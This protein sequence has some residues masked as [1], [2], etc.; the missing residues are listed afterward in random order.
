MIYVSC[1]NAVWPEESDAS[2]E[3]KDRTLQRETGPAIARTS[4]AW[5]RALLALLTLLLSAPSAHAIF[6][7]DA[8]SASTG[9]ISGLWWNPNE[10]GWGINLTQQGPIIF[11]AWYTYDQT[12][13]P[14][15]YVM[16]N[17]AVA[18]DSC[19]GDIYRVVGGKPLST[20]W[21]GNGLVVTKAGAGSLTFTDNNTGVFRYTL[22]GV[23][24]TRN[25][26]RQIFAS[27]AT[28][29]EVDYS[30]LW[31]NANESGWG[32]ALTQQYGVIFVTMFTYDASGN[33]V[34][35]VASN[36]AV[37]ASGCTG[38]LYK[39]SGG[40]VPTTPWV[41]PITAT[42]VGNITI[43]FTDASNGTMNFTINGQSG[44]RAISK[45]IFYTPP[46]LDP[47]T[48]ITNT[49][50]TIDSA[51]P[52]GVKNAISQIISPAGTSAPGGQVGI[53]TT[54]NGGTSIVLAVDAN[55]N[56]LLA[57]MAN[58]AATSVSA[59]STAFAFARIGM[60][61]ISTTSVTE[62][63]VSLAIR[64]TAEYANLVKLI[65][66]SLSAITPPV[67]STAVL[68]SVA[69]VDSQA[70]A[71]LRSQFGAKDKIAY[72]L[73]YT[74]VGDAL[75][76]VYISSTDGNGVKVMNSMPIVWTVSSTD[77]SGLTL[78]GPKPLPAGS[79]LEAMYKI[80]DAVS[81]GGNG[82][83][84]KVKI[85][86][87]L[88][89]RTTNAV[90][91]GVDAVLFGVSLASAGQSGFFRVCATKA[92][93]TVLSTKNLSLLVAEPSAE[94]AKI[95]F[96]G[97]YKDPGLY[98]EIGSGLYDCIKAYGTKKDADIDQTAN[99]VVAAD[100]ADWIDKL[101][102]VGEFLSKFGPLS[103]AISGA[104]LF[105]ETAMMWAYW[106]Y[107]DQTVRVCER[108]GAI[109]STCSIQLV[110]SPASPSV[111][112]GSTVPLT[113]TAVDPSNASVS[114]PVPTEL[115][116]DSSNK[117]VATVTSAGVVT[118]VAAGSS[119]ITVTDP[120]GSTASVVVEVTAAVAAKLVL[121]YLSK[122]AEICQQTVQEVTNAYLGT[123]QVPEVLFCNGGY[124]SVTCSSGCSNQTFTISGAYE[125]VLQDNELP[126]CDGQTN[127][128]VTY[129]LETSTGLIVPDGS[130]VGGTHRV[131]AY[132]IRV[133]WK[134]TPPVVKC[135]HTGFS[136]VTLSVTSSTG[137]S[138]TFAYVAE[139]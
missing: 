37:S 48:A 75:A 109:V 20:A 103:T 106:D 122:T 112:V 30:A 34:W 97:V 27:G 2:C 63:Q 9:P 7:V 90:Q 41:G 107:P 81:V 130:T 92:A 15:W 93:V 139:H 80:P 24:G 71:T 64:G 125:Q 77:L 33:P 118:G 10:S 39:T 105:T 115:T 73:P 85:G 137:L 35:Y 4:W 124:V 36:C 25:I 57:A 14:L 56:V 127:F 58:S 11:A 138:K 101:I 121:T 31:W 96:D 100:S 17:C 89:S 94:M 42:A 26:T 70:L 110:I 76:S 111:N 69:S 40:T 3:S 68:A 38:A 98:K 29:P 47:S 13:A 134:G 84:F 12:G 133:S 123:E 113:V 21:N 19:T 52:S 99:V 18:T 117:S 83:N 88:A 32:V 74:F 22:N 1:S 23:A 61:N 44:T 78:D 51:V 87:T 45:Q 116:W 5:W 91:S 114:V 129:P 28:A 132:K 135:G 120:A 49:T 67:Q 53:T 102:F 62:A 131:N 60:G 43:A 95:Y 119:T 108:D 72:S 128:D 6:T 59:D 8:T 16:S 46:T 86:Q 79:I 55:S 54:A 82:K 66:Q 50:V 126:H 104:G 65:N 136:G